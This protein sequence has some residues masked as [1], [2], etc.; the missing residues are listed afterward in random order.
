ML[1]VNELN[2]VIGV[3]TCI[4]SFSINGNYF[5]VILWYAINWFIN[6]NKLCNK[7]KYIYIYI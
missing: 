6:E 2:L 4:K 1:F 7:Y 3:E 5:H